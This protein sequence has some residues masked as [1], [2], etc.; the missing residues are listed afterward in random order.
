MATS[1]IE[2]CNRALRAIGE[3]T[4]TSLTDDSTRAGLC[5]LQYEPV[6]D[7]ILRAHPWKFAIARTDLAASEASP[8]FGYDY[9]YP[10]PS[11]NIRLL[12]IYDS[13]GELIDDEE[14]W[15]LE[16]GSIV[17]DATAP[18]YIKYI[19]RETNP[20]K[21]DPLFDEA[22]VARL[23]AT[24]ANDMSKETGT[25]DRQWELYSRKI[26][27]AQFVDSTESSPHEDYVSAWEEARA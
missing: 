6:R 17:T 12:S 25:I 5:D 24:I 27:E 7:A 4:I 1:V 13:S 11:D 15:T 26:A 16:S 10:L 23:A 22:L 9:A 18:I 21:F 3:N 19:K 8:S 2:I 14:S 20:A